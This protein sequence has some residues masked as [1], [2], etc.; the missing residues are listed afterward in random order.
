MRRWKESDWLGAVRDPII[1]GS[2]LLQVRACSRERAYDQ[3]SAIASLQGWGEPDGMIAC[4][5]TELEGSQSSHLLTLFDE[6][7]R[8]GAFNGRRP[9][10]EQG[11][12]LAI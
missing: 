8:E 11:R 12:P 9:L 4:Q 1:R 7:A 6:Q 5:L 10:F 2:H 3:A